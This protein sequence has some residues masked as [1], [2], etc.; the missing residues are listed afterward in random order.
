MNSGETCS[1]A[2]GSSD[3]LTSGLWKMWIERGQWT[4]M[5]GCDG[6]QRSE[7][8]KGRHRVQVDFSPQLPS[9]LGADGLGGGAWGG[10]SLLETPCVHLATPWQEGLAS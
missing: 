8:Q 3:L 7:G 6:K 5:G 9:G 10:P 2:L 4:F 1:G